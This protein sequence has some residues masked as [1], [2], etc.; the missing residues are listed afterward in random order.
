MVTDSLI[1]FQMD[2]V[3]LILQT[4]QLR[5]GINDAPSG[6]LTQTQLQQVIQLQMQQIVLE[7]LYRMT[8]M[9]MQVLL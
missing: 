7:Q 8:L 2:K 3:K 9:L 4:Q 5:S 1:T 6:V